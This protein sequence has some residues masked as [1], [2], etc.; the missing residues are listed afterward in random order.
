M[1]S[2]RP[3]QPPLPLMASVW[4]RPWRASCGS[5]GCQGC[6]TLTMDQISSQ[7]RPQF[8]AAT[9]SP[10]RTVRE[11]RHGRQAAQG[12]SPLAGAHQ[13]AESS[14]LSSSTPACFVFMERPNAATAHQNSRLVRPGFHVAQGEPDDRG[15]KQTEGW[16]RH[17]GR[18]ARPGAWRRSTPPASARRRREHG[19]RV[20]QRD[21]ERSNRAA[22]QRNATK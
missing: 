10:P 17:S 1:A 20:Y 21:G 2:V 15:L 11:G 18:R 19:E 14:T 22:T 5:P 4:P 3:I 16:W 7:A 6:N 13:A 9:D 12:G 8:V